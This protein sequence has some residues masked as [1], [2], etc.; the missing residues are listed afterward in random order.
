MDFLGNKFKDAMPI[1][2]INNIRNI[3]TSLNILAVEVG[4]QNSATDFFSTNLSVANTNIRT[5]GKGTSYRYALASAYGEMMERLQNQTFFRLNSDMRH[6]NLMHNGFYYAPDEINQSY[7][8]IISSDEEWITTQFNNMKTDLSK[9][10]L[11]KKWKTVS[12]ESTPSDFISLPFMNINTN[13]ISHIPIKMLSKMYMSNGMC[14][15]NSAY[16]AIV[17]GLSE[18]FERYVNKYII[19]NKITPPTVPD[20][21][22][23]RYPRILS[24]ITQIRASGNY[25][26][27]IKDCSLGKGY[28]VVGLIYFNK[29]DQ[30]YFIKLGSHPVFEIA[31]E[32]TLTELLQGQDIK[33]MKGVKEYSYTPK[34]Q[35]EKNN[36]IGILVNGSGLYPSEL[37]ASNPSYEF[38][39][40][41]EFEHSDNKTLLNFLVNLLKKQGHDVFV[42]DVSFLGFPSYHVI[43]PNFSEIEGIDDIEAIDD[44]SKYN[45]IKKYIRN[46]DTLTNEQILEI[47]SFFKTYDYNKEA[48][49]TQFLNINVKDVFPWYYSKVDL[50]LTALYI[51]LGDY[52]KAYETIEGY[53]NHMSSM[54]YS[55]LE[56]TYYKCARDFI[57]TKADKLPDDD[58]M[59][60]LNLVYPHMVIK[61]VIS[62]F[63]DSNR[64]LNTYGQ[65]ECFN[66]EQCSL[67]KHC[68]VNTNTDVY[69]I[70]KDKYLLN[71]IDQNMLTNL[72]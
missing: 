20:D 62:D 39:E 1:D 10:D 43:V 72:I 58:A 30:T 61:G 65:I 46:L 32:R 27:I 11:L 24:M 56:K 47:I 28:P 26:V 19:E 13:N 40:F 44:Y 29:D 15:G 14:G 21:Y 52:N 48:N 63:G 6:E 22:L 25:D 7:D 51:K 17:Q 36:L 8:D 45:K 16:E 2:T 64:I 33:N 55:S 70:L 66:C 35:N 50:F 49:I 4:W 37:F 12:Y 42:R 9:L 69:K 23:M 5:N 53:V 3:L 38:T 60:L 71:K 41:E 34:I 59:T 68:L 54:P 67:K 57:A 18:V 31:L